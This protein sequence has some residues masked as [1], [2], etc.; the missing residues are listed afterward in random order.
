MFF[1]RFHLFS[2]LFPKHTFL[3]HN[4][5]VDCPPIATNYANELIA[6]QKYYSRATWKDNFLISPMLIQSPVS[7][8][9]DEQIY[10]HSNT[11]SSLSRYFA[12]PWPVY[13]CMYTYTYTLTLI[14]RHERSLSS[15]LKIIRVKIRC[16]PNL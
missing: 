7:P 10:C 13:M 6:S 16:W 2:N 3:S 4:L 11:F 5:L 9:Y 1:I 15:R 14:D 12:N 8:I